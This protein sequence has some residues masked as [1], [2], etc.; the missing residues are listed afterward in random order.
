MAWS[1]SWSLWPATWRTSA[2]PCSPTG[3][4]SLHPR[5]LGPPPLNAGQILWLDICAILGV[6]DTPLMRFKV[7][8]LRENMDYQGNLQMMVFFDILKKGINSGYLKWSNLT[9]CDSEGHE[10][11]HGGHLHA[12]QGGHQPNQIHS[13]PRYVLKKSVVCTNGWIFLNQWMRKVNLVL[14]S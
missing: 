2:G 13:H 4:L 11:E 3:S 9:H 1:T 12:G 8:K 6:S 14:Y 5:D 10:E 7:Y